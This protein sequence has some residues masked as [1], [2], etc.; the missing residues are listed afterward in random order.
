MKAGKKAAWAEDKKF[1]VYGNALKDD[2]QFVPIAVETFATWGS[3]G[4]KFITDIGRTIAEITKN[5]KT[6]S[7]PH[8]FFK[9]YQWQFN[10]QMYYVC[11]VL[12]EKLPLK[13]LMKSS[14]F[15]NQTVFFN[16][17]LTF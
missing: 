7:Q 5:P 15:Y 10:V 17:F 2:Y 14:T 1:T 6:L 13:N 4:H 9:L 3:I 16:S 11:K 12:M 8:L